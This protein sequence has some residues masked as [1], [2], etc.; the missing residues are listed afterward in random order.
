M[1]DVFLDT[2]GLIAVVDDIDQWHAAAKVAYEGLLR[3]GHRLVATPLV[4]YLCVYHLLPT[5]GAGLYCLVKCHEADLDWNHGPGR[6]GF[7]M[8]Q[9][10]E[11]PAVTEELLTEVVRRVR[12][13]G[14]PH[15]SVPNAFETVA[16]REGRVLFDAGEQ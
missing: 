10:V 5:G 13:V 12:R 3:Q 9:T 16:L 6:W 4:M 11:Y 14:S 7:V 2:V 15:K 1:K 8:S